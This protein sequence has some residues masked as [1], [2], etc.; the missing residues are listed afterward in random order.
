MDR[1]IATE[2]DP[3]VTCVT[4]DGMPAIR[5]GIGHRWVLWGRGHFVNHQE[6]FDIVAFVTVIA[7]PTGT[8]N[9]TV[10][11]VPVLVDAAFGW[12]PRRLVLPPAE[13]L[14][15]IMSMGNGL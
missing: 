7:P 1:R 6:T 3:L 5:A 11:L 14:N 8:R 2:F 10:V 13:T 4:V 15:T 9:G 12:A